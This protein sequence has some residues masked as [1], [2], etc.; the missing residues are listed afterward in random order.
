MSQN[1]RTAARS[2]FDHSG[3][4]NR[5]TARAVLRCSPAPALRLSAALQSSCVTRYG[6][7][8]CESP[9][10][11]GHQYGD[12]LATV[13]L[14]SSGSVSGSERRLCSEGNSRDGS[15]GFLSPRGKRCGGLRRVAP[16]LKAFDPCGSTYQRYA[17]TNT[18]SRGAHNCRLC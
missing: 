3:R 8:Y 15:R 18:I 2:F 17:V 1:S 14:A 7:G 5:L 13:R 10:A 4:R 6:S 12:A 11:S 16:P 9:Y